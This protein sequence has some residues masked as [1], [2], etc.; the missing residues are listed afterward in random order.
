[1]SNIR[2]A[3]ALV[4][5]ACWASFAGGTVRGQCQGQI[6]HDTGTCYDCQN[7]P[8]QECHFNSCNSCDDKRCVEPSPQPTPVPLLT[9]SGVGV[10]LSRL[11]ATCYA[12]DPKIIAASLKSVRPTDWSLLASPASGVSLSFFRQ[13]D[14]PA[15]VVEMTFSRPDL[16]KA[17]TI[18]NL[19]GKRI[20]A[21]QLGWSLIR[22]KMVTT[23]VSERIVL[24]EPSRP[25]TEIRLTQP[26]RTIDSKSAMPG[27]VMYFVAS[28]E[29]S[30]GSR[31]RQDLKNIQ[32]PTAA[33]H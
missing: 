24:D 2:W 32:I 23:S 28:V 12:D 31:W 16:F 29:F 18:Q 26:V 8:G 3:C 30:D 14:A 1:M 10:G 6:C 5:L 11:M 22:G 15:S 21:L 27:L 4:C 33:A 13:D 25:D 20:I 17:A 9:S 7:S 19:S